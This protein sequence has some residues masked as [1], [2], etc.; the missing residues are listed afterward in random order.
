[1]YNFIDVNQASESV[2]L[3][4]EALKINGEY[5]EN[6]IKGYRT[7]HVSG[8]EA[9]APELSTYTTGVRDGS[10]MKNKRFPA[11]T[12]TVTYQIIAE[13]SE[14]YRKAYNKLAAILN[15][16]NA[17]LIFNDEQDKYFV[18]TPSVIGTPEPGRNAVIGEFDI[19]CLDPFKYSV[20]EY[21]TEPV[22]AE[23][24]FV[25]DYGGTYKTYPK[26]EVE[27]YKETEIS[28]DGEDFNVLTGKGDCGYIA[29]I[30]ERKKI[31]QLGDPDEA[32]TEI[33]ETKSKTLIHNEFNKESDWGSFAKSQ[34]DLNAF[35]KLPDIFNTS[36]QDAGPIGSVGMKYVYP[37]V[38]VT[39]E[40]AEKQIL[41]V[42]S[43]VGPASTYPVGY[44]GFT[45][46]V[47]TKMTQRTETTA[48]IQVTVNTAMWKESNYFGYGLTAALYVEGKWHERVLR[49]DKD[50]TWHGK[51]NH[52]TIFYIT[53]TGLTSAAGKAT[54]VKFKTARTGNTGT[55]GIVAETK[56]HDIEY[57]A[58]TLARNN[59]S[60]FL[61]VTNYGAVI[62]N[63]VTGP[64]ISRL[65]PGETD[66]TIQF[67]LFFYS[68]DKKKAIE[69]TGRFGLWLES[70]EGPNISLWINKVKNTKTAKWQLQVNNRDV[71]SSFS[72]SKV[73]IPE[74]NVVDRDTPIP[75][76]ITWIGKKLHFDWDGKTYSYDVANDFHW[77]QSNLEGLVCRRVSFI[78]RRVAH[79]PLSHLGVSE[80]KYIRHNCNNIKDI[81]NKFV[82]NDVLKVDCRTGEI[83]LNE[84]QSPA[85]GALGNDWEEFF[86]E[87]GINQMQC[88]HS[89]W[90]TDE[91][92]PKVRMR[93][94]EVFL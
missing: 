24:T 77:S 48:T 10:V 22:D 58:Y 92:A 75:V 74:L 69:Q 51:N 35:D 33:V 86:L 27:F 87:P 23:G 93:Y 21:I 3:P 73:P 29:F 7:L 12:I 67:K 5:I 34:W 65:V 85:L 9:F 30:N 84:I 18:G 54:G 26:F 81:P 78:F 43:K 83:L 89:D 11:R 91:Y 20:G 49:T 72:L 66:F 61:G 41:S 38:N 76:A 1:M 15:V 63:G 82:A 14:E 28:E 57:T 45:Y 62:S 19:L 88:V 79:E 8:R 46:T 90:V 17:E 68:A 31:I 25:I 44:P 56:C 80:I 39:K 71:F 16:E 47:Y 64:S 42:K 4:S 94:R 50:S 32:D 13:S 59:K 70:Q 37:P 60:C 52:R 53:L 36:S 55:A 2:I 6:Q 40:S